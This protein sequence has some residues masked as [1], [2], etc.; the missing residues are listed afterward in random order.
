MEKIRTDFWAKPIPLRQ[1]D[2]SATYD[3]YE[4]GDPIGYGRSE[5]DAVLDLIENHPC[6]V[7]CERNLRVASHRCLTS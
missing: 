5:A 6:G 4:G 1:F 2:W 3:S 7:Q